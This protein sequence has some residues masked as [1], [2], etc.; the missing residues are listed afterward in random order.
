MGERGRGGRLEVWATLLLPGHMR[1]P[2]SLSFPIC[3]MGPR[4]RWGGVWASATHQKPPLSPGSWSACSCPGRRRRHLG[5]A[6]V[7]EGRGSPQASGSPTPTLDPPGRLT[8]AGEGRGEAGGDRDRKRQR[9]TDRETQRPGTRARQGEAGT[10]RGTH[11][12][13]PTTAVVPGNPGSLCTCSRYNRLRGEV[14]ERWGLP[15]L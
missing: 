4:P 2:L 6:G 11:S 10:V 13:H 9:L 5:T 3:E 7:G 14:G 12:C 15:L 8:E 1:P